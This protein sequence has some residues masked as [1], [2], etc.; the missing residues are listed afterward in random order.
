MRLR[1]TAG[2]WR[3][4]ARWFLTCRERAGGAIAPVLDPGP[5]AD[6]AR[7]RAR[8]TR[9]QPVVRNIARDTYDVFLRANRVEAGIGSYDQ[10]VRLILGAGADHGWLRGCVHSSPAR[11]FA[12]SP[13]GDG[14]DDSLSDGSASRRVGPRRGSPLHDRH[15]ARHLPPPQRPRLLYIAP[16]AK[17]LSDRRE[18]QRIHSLVIPPGVDRR[19]DLSGSARPSPGDRP[20]RAR[21]QAASLSSEM[22][23]GARR[24]E[25]SPPDR[26]C[27]RAAGD[28]AAHQRR[29]AETGPQAGEGRW[30]PSC[31]CSR[32][33]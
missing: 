29:P 8:W 27:P 32:R 13:A 19:L 26:V 22:A 24:N 1:S 30:L 9:S 16:S 15:E 2:G 4:T 17:R 12:V 18:L 33:R 21:A 20:R 3:C 5:Q 7:S 11:G 14:K 31:S 23:R 28:P 6:F 10:V 25:V